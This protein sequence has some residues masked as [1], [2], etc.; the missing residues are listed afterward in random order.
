MACL[1]VLNGNKRDAQLR[2]THYECSSRG[3]VYPRDVSK[4]PFLFVPIRKRQLAI[5]CG[6]VL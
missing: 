2:T 4:L 5:D 6:D 3:A 1:N